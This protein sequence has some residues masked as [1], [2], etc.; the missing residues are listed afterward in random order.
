MARQR[1]YNRDM[2]LTKHEH[3]YKMA[4]C[5]VNAV[6]VKLPRLRSAI[7]TILAILKE[8]ILITYLAIK[9]SIIGQSEFIIIVESLGERISQ[10]L[11]RAEPPG[12]KVKNGLKVLLKNCVVKGIQFLEAK[13]QTGKGGSTRRLGELG[14]RENIY[15]LKDLL[16]KGIGFVLN[17]ALVKDSM[18]I[19]LN[20][21]LIIRPCASIRKT[22]G[23]FALNAIRQ[24]PILA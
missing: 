8:N 13:T 10:K 23:F 16:E 17:A 9:Q 24:Q 15:I 22:Q 14:G 18:S 19:I 20:R 4:I 2:A 3:Q 1:V 21:L 5:F 6:A 11:L 12:T 7:D